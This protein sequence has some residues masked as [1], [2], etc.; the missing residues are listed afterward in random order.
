MTRFDKARQPGDSIDVMR[1]IPIQASSLPSALMLVVMALVFA[2]AP[3]PI[4]ACLQPGSGICTC[5]CEHEA[6]APMACCGDKGNAPADNHDADS[7]SPLCCF[8]LD[9]ST[10]PLTLQGRDTYCPAPF[11]SGSLEVA[12][13]RYDEPV[14][15]VSGPEACGPPPSPRRHLALCQFLL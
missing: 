10:E 5:C 8:T 13:I 14:L 4:H 9:L 3:V 1:L 6:S 15:R 2:L 7:S 12:T 11:A